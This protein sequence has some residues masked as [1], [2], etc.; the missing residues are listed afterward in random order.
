MIRLAKIH[1]IPEILSITKAC[2]E[3]MIRQ[4]IFQWNETYPSQSAF[5]KDIERNEL[6]V[7]EKENTLVGC[8][9]LTSYM[10]EEYK[11]VAWL[12]PNQN[13]L[14]I[15]R[16]AVHPRFQ[17]QGFAQQLMTF[18][19]NFALQ[20]TYLSIRLDTFSRNKRNQHFYTLRGYSRLGEIYFPNQ[21]DYPF[22]C[23]EKICRP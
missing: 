10:D 6:Y 1:E 8:I 22:Y 13:N 17:H 7:L 15:H 19:E 11:T 21:S 18:A 2:A 9:V 14:Y 20:N 12:T 3:E 4:N 5:E 16:L 23:Y